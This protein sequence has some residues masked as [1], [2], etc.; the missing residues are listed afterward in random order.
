MAVQGKELTDVELSE[1]VSKLKV[2]FSKGYNQLEACLYAGI[3]KFTYYKYFGDD[4]ELLAEFD[5]HKSNPTMLAKDNIMESLAE[6][7][8]NT[9]KYVLDR[10]DPDYKP[11]TTQ[12]LVTDDGKGGEAPINTQPDIDLSKLS[13]SALNELEQLH[14]DTNKSSEV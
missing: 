11:T 4:A 9:S 6:G 2:G 3:S 8:I 1:V 13:L 5:R 14:A 12:K 7:D 10:K